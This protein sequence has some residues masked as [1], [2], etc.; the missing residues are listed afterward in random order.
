MLENRN[1]LAI[2]E[3]LQS[4]M[5]KAGLDGMIINAPEAIFYATRLS[6]S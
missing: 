4:C 1:Q 5:E 3:R 2:Q 6:D